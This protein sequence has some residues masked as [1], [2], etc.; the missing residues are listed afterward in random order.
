MER[1]IK[2]YKLDS[3]DAQFLR[4]SMRISNQR[5]ENMMNAHRYFICWVSV[6]R[7]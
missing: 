1:I 5:A 4:D 2:S 6:I 7:G 3:P